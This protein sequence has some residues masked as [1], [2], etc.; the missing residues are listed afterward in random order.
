MSRRDR[1]KDEP[2]RLRLPFHGGATT[3]IDHTIYPKAD[4]PAYE[5]LDEAARIIQSELAILNLDFESELHEMSSDQLDFR[6][7]FGELK[8]QLIQKKIA[9]EPL[10]KLFNYKVTKHL[11]TMFS[12]IR[13]LTGVATQYERSIQKSTA[14][15]AVDKML[16]LYASRVVALQQLN[17][18]DA[19][20]RESIRGLLTTANDCARHGHDAYATFLAHEGKLDALLRTTMSDL[21][22]RASVIHS[23]E[24]LEQ[25]WETIT[26]LLEPV[27]A[28]FIIFSRCSQ[29]YERN[30][31]AFF[32]ARDGISLYRGEWTRQQK[33]IQ[34]LDELFAV[35]EL[36]PFVLHEKLHTLSRAV[37]LRMPDEVARQQLEAEM[38]Q[39]FPEP[40]SNAVLERAEKVSE[41]IMGRI[42]MLGEATASSN[43]P[44]EPMEL[45][46]CTF[47]AFVV[48]YGNGEPH[49]GSGRT[50]RK[51]YDSMLVP[52]QLHF[53]LSKQQFLEAIEAAK[54]DGLL[55]ETK[56]VLGRRKEKRLQPT[57][58]GFDVAGKLFE[59]LP[60]D[61]AKH[62]RERHEVLRQ[63]SAEM[64]EKFRKKEK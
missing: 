49:P 51:V 7:F 40:L 5:E 16:D 57:K 3:A 14:G 30:A 45:A 39:A 63:E 62:I 15:G 24:A 34:G 37:A 38:P 9:P 28:A 50:P 32:V 12:C 54:Q 4:S 1:G 20:E 29:N 17:E 41:A 10:A 21:A 8:Q 11:R 19:R 42:G 6:P 46:V 53:G 48:K 13:Q 52:T 23:V 25:R 64:R 26:T 33:A 2:R 60:V 59:R 31:S 55:Q 58:I 35:A 36:D 61:F 47:A 18:H 56:I 27:N 43:C 22:N 44:I